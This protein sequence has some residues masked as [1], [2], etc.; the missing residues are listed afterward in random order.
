MGILSGFGMASDTLVGPLESRFSAMA[1]AGFT[2]VML[3]A[4]DV[5]SHP[6]GASAV[7]RMLQRSGLQALGYQTL[8]AFEGLAGSLHDY[9]VA[10]AKSMLETCQALGSPL[11]LASSSTYPHASSDP[12]V[13]AKDLRKLAMLALPLGIQV[14]YS[15]VAEGRSINAHANAYDAV[16][17]ADC[18]NLGLALAAFPMHAAET[19]AD[20]M[21][22]IDTVED[23]DPSRIYL[24]QLS[25]RIWSDAG[26]APQQQHAIASS[27][28]VF[29]GEGVHTDYLADLVLRL[30]AMG[31]QGNY[32]FAV[33][34]ADYLQLPAPFVAQR[35]RRSGL[36]LR[37][38]VLRRSA[39]LPLTCRF[40]E[41]A[42]TDHRDLA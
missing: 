5:A 23:L 1:D 42:P 28:S 9:K 32:T 24:V 29:P 39:P 38:D 30:D 35:A 17:Q 14:A 37:E 8:H 3:S 11:L 21:D 36:W 19:S 40:K 20:A 4:A 15:A 33:H 7:A 25:D 18:P 41:A 26:Y 13:I 2:Q 31:Y 6:G 12:D 16:C 22:A 10:I 27:P 34:N